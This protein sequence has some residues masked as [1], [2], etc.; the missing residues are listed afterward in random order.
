VRE[1]IHL[2]DNSF[3]ILKAKK[4]P[5]VDAVI[6]D[7]GQEDRELARGLAEQ[8]SKKRNQ[9]DISEMMADQLAYRAM[10][11]GRRQPIVEL[12]LIGAR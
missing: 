6:N 5:A 11:A 10:L 4:I 7:F 1:Q 8:F 2:C 12:V 3:H 9:Y